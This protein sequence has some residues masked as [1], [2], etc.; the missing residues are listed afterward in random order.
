MKIF[1]TLV[2]LA[3]SSNSFAGDWFEDWVEVTVHN[4]VNQYS[5]E[6]SCDITH[7][8]ARYQSGWATHTYKAE[9]PITYYENIILYVN[10]FTGFGYAFHNNDVPNG[11]YKCETTV[12]F[13]QTVVAGSGQTFFLPLP[14]FVGHIEA[15]KL[16]C[17]NTN[18]R[19]VSLTLDQTIGATNMTVH[20]QSGY[21]NYANVLEYSGQA[22]DN[23]LVNVVADTNLT[24][25]RVRLDNGSSTYITL[26][27]MNCSGGG[28]PVN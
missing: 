2:L 24:N 16:G 11:S 3:L 12:P 22:S 27:G 17:I 23:V 28:G 26:N 9:V 5:G 18:T 20:S 25:I 15:E 4:K 1:I 14:P 21:N 19:K 6:A 7:P 10:Q 13:A 8:D